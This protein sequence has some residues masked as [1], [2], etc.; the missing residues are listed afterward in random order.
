MPMVHVNMLEGR[1]PAQKKALLAGITQVVQD[2]LGSPL[3]AIR[4]W[5]TEFPPTDYMSSGIVASER[6]VGGPQP[7]GES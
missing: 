6:R 4:V 1:T 3:E 7:T 2:T 5:I